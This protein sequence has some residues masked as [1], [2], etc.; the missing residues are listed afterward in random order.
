VGSDVFKLIAIKQKRRGDRFY[1][2]IDNDFTMVLK[3]LQ[4]V[5]GLSATEF[6]QRVDR[7]WERMLEIV[8]FARTKQHRTLSQILKTF[9]GTENSSKLTS[10]ERS[11]LKAIFKLLR[12][13]YARAGIKES[14]LAKDQP[15]FYTMVTAILALNLIGQYG[16]DDLQRRLAAMSQIIDGKAHAPRGMAKVLKEY[17]ELSS[18]QTTHPGRRAA[19]QERFAELLEAV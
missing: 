7:M 13:L 9:L 4:A 19:R 15:H 14:R 5:A 12:S 11:T 10:E 18:K 1:K 16:S 6:Q 8:L 3:R 2:M 17:M